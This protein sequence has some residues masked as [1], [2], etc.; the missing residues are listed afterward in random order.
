MC[1]GNTGLYTFAWPSADANST[2]GQS[3]S[4][5]QCVKWSSI[6]DWAYSRMLANDETEN[7]RVIFPDE[8][9]KPW[10]E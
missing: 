3:N 10:E 5:S 8:D 9:P 6:E 4:Q 1:H 7:T 2:T